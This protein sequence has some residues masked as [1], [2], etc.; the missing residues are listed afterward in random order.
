MFDRVEKGVW[1]DKSWNPIRLKDGG[2]GCTKVSPGCANCWAERYSRRFFKTP[3]YDGRRREF[4]L[5]ERVLTEPLRARKPRVYFVCDLMDLFHKDVP[6]SFIL[7]VFQT[8]LRGWFDCNAAK[9]GYPHIHILLTKRPKRMA[10]F[11]KKYFNNEPCPNR[12]WLGVSVEDQKTA[13]ERITELLKLPAA[14]I[15]VSYEPALGGLILPTEFLERGKGA[16]CIVGGETGPGARP[17]LYHWA[18]RV[19]K[20]C[21]DADIPFFFKSHGEWE[22]AL[23]RADPDRH[24]LS[25]CRGIFDKN[26]AWISDGQWDYRLKRIGKKQAGRL[27]DG[28]EWNQIPE[29]SRD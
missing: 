17:M 19:S 12:I 4:M 15:V 18:Q 3:P 22:T 10:Q 23:D 21:R 1:W 8:M 16:W 25:R 20:Q 27:L 14:V 24:P 7:T 9:W 6:D 5:N 28:K 29:M 26:T 11:W 13:D 2:F